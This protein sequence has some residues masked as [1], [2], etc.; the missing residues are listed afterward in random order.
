MNFNQEFY[1]YSPLYKIMFPS[2]L[3]LTRQ[4]NL[5]YYKDAIQRLS[6]LYGGDENIPE[7]LLVLVF[8]D[9][10]TDQLYAMVTKKHGNY[11][12]ENFKYEDKIDFD[13]IMLASDEELKNEYEK[14]LP[15]KKMYHM[16]NDN[17]IRIGGKAKRGVSGAK[18][19]TK[20]GFKNVDVTS[21]S[22]TK[23]GDIVRP[24]ELSPLKGGFGTT[25]DDGLIYKNFENWWQSQK[26][27]KELGHI[28][29]KGGLTKK[30][31]DWRKKWAS[32]DE[33]KRTLPG[34][35]GLIPVGSYHDGKIVGYI[36]SRKY[37]IPKYCGAIKDKKSILIMVE[38]LKNGEKIMILDGD[39]PRSSEFPEG[40]DFNWKG[41]DKFYHSTKIPFGHGY[42]VAGILKLLSSPP[43]QA[44]L[45]Q[46]PPLIIEKL[47][48]SLTVEESIELDLFS[49]IIKK[50]KYSILN[51]RQLI[52]P[53]NIDR[54]K[55]TSIP[56]ILDHFVTILDITGCSNLTS[57][58]D[59]INLKALTCS[60]C[61]RLAK[62]PDT[63]INLEWL[64]CEKCTNISVIPST[65]TQLKCLLCKSCTK[66][67]TIPDTLIE[68]T[69]IDC[70][71][72]PKLT[73]ISTTMIERLNFF[74]CDF[75]TQQEFW[76]LHVEFIE[77]QK[78]YKRINTIK[79]FASDWM[80][81]NSNGPP[82]PPPPPPVDPLPPRHNQPPLPS[83]PPLVPKYVVP[84]EDQSDGYGYG[85]LWKFTDKKNITHLD[86]RQNLLE[87]GKP[88]LM[89]IA[90]FLK[91]PGANKLSK[92]DLRQLLSKLISFEPVDLKKE[93]VEKFYSLLRDIKLRID[94]DEYGDEDEDED[95]EGLIIARKN[96]REFITSLNDPMV[97]NTPYKF[98][99]YRYPYS[100]LMNILVFGLAD[101]LMDEIE[102][103][104]KAG[105]DV[106][107]HIKFKLFGPV[108]DTI[109]AESPLEFLISFP[110]DY[111][112][113]EGVKMF[114]KNGAIITPR[115]LELAKEIDEKGG[116]SSRDL[117]YGDTGIMLFPYLNMMSSKYM[118]EDWMRLNTNGQPLSTTPSQATKQS[119][120]P[121]QATKQSATPSQATKQSATPSQKDD[122]EIDRLS[123]YSLVSLKSIA[124]DLGISGLSLFKSGNKRELA[125]KIYHNIE[126]RTHLP[127]SVVEHEYELL[128]C[129]S[130][131]FYRKVGSI[132]FPDPKEFKWIR[133]N[134]C[135]I[136][137]IYSKYMDK[138]I[139][140][141]R[142]AYLI[143]TLNWEVY[144]NAPLFFSQA[145]LKEYAKK[146]G[147]KLGTNAYFSNV[148][149]L[150]DE[151]N[152]TKDMIG[153]WMRLKY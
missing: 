72:C 95:E 52:I 131:Y 100:A 32:V 108:D 143:F 24:S 45:P 42:V 149:R 113:I 38:M 92:E 28:D 101:V 53:K 86:I 37:Y 98:E 12:L 74:D 142:N 102:L 82:L 107:E 146:H 64:D 114:V 15:A 50:D 27:F 110:R 104:F 69:Q 89:T 26:I 36:E 85:R 91:I 9:I 60:G 44:S 41:I 141:Y 4:I 76:K 116:V 105:S 54:K 79:D 63:M 21:G 25:A 57:L 150:D 19:A 47:G 134:E 140:P 129:G 70:R 84:R 31:F 61:T 17:N 99:N 139:N 87:E 123:E 97:L 153:D 138:I 48:R 96:F 144:P 152:N 13:Y 78:E 128:K 112:Y 132:G 10:R 22:M 122:N 109:H 68:L 124:T 103:M 67:T 43:P 145:D 51:S 33:G 7:G 80:R 20:S 120:T 23:L 2:P 90:S 119:A 35:S 34:T 1:Y 75:M 55:L 81:F 58:P 130:R 115:V 148:R 117:P 14:R 125:E 6:I 3:K 118:M 40:V 59:L 8:D 65:L 29:D 127:P 136:S 77:L 66:L 111:L 151:Y 46:D 39:A 16:G 18:N 147:I 30:F 121:S 56:K 133:P 106:N 5:G 49:E 11:Y 88:I 126:K 93:K 73:R 71:K 62:I 137:K 94:G 83:P 135:K